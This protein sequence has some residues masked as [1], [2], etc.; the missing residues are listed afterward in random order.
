MN[1]DFGFLLA[2]AKVESGLNPNARAGSST[3]TGLFQ[4]V[5]GTWL[6][7]MRRHGPALGLE[8]EAAAISD[9]ARG[10]RVS[11]PL[12]RSQILAMRNDPRIASLLAGALARD[13][14]AALTPV[15]GREPDAGELY[16]AHFMGAQGASRFLKA[17]AVSPDR[18][19][20]ELFA[21]AA[22]ANRSIFYGQGGNPRSLAGV[23]D[24]LRGKIETAMSDEIAPVD[25]AEF[26][27]LAAGYGWQP[28]GVG[29]A[30]LQMPGISMADKTRPP[31]TAIL[32][33]SFALNGT[34]AGPA[35]GDHARRAYA[36]L[37]A[38]GL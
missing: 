34:D 13:N 36:R 19:A 31:I 16:L 20:V 1:V 7:V 11:D 8:Q 30:S 21:N 38:F 10:P 18:P 12:R 26:T 27:M 5:E 15:L 25:Q 2:Q 29:R 28:Y 17:M 35:S 33:D 9:T 23:M 22:S 6:D 32:R 3:A 4:F 37:K 24:L 14:R